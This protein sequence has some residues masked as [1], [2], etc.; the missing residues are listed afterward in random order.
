MDLIKYVLGKIILTHLK[1]LP[2]PPGPLPP[3]STNVPLFFLFTKN[4]KK[5]LFKK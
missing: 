2:P 5:M 4:T 3:P 1:K